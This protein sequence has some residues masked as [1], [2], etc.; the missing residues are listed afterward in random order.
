VMQ[1]HN[2]VMADGLH[3]TLDTWYIGPASRAKAILRYW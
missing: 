3:G 2:K 1:D